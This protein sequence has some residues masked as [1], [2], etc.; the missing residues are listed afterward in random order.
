MRN[1]LFCLSFV[2]LLLVAFQGPAEADEP[3]VPF[4]ARFEFLRNGKLVGES[5]FVFSVDGAQWR[6]TTDTRGTR[7][8]ARFLGLEESSESTGLWE[9][10]APV[11]Q[12]FFQSV[13]VSFKTIETLAE[14][15]WEAGKVRSVHDDGEDLLDLE[16]GVLDPV[17][18]GLAVR[19]GL[20]SGKTEWRLP[21][22]DEDEIE[23]QQFRMAEEASIDTDLGC[24][25]TR[26]VDRIRGPESTRYTQTWYARDHAWV[27][28]RVAH[29]KTDGDRM[30]SRIV[31]LTVDGQEVAG[32]APCP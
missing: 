23:E 17:S 11:P 13:E 1:N 27:P 10:G 16:P 6:M 4:D 29:G 15:D 25:A 5:R 31:S 12:R 26:R 7:G 9:D 2:G 32:G 22:V 28:V 30:E 20:A 3:P 8:L 24:L 19:A 14:F 18:V 21:L